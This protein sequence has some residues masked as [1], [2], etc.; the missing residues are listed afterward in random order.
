MLIKKQISPLSVNQCWQGQRFKTKAY[1]F[2][3]AELLLT[4]P[5]QKLPPAPYSIYFEFGFSNVMSDWDNPVKPLQDI[6]QKKYQFND[7]DIF[8]A[9]VVKRK[10]DKGSE[11]FLVKLE[12]F[13][14]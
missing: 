5:T 11:Y 4:L 12:T 3:E 2:Y 10:V 6:L 7:K 13:K 1:K 9:R 8:E 14:N